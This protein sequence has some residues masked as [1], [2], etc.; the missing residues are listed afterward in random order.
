[1]DREYSKPKLCEKCNR[2]MKPS[3]HPRIFREGF[4]ITELVKLYYDSCEW[5]GYEFEYWS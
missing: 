3:L 5:C 2:L 4:T 1:M